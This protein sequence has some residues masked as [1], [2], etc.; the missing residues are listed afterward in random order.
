MYL[1]IIILGYLFYNE[2]QYDSSKIYYYKAISLN[3]KYTDAYYN[4]AVTF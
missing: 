2:N 3:P 1:H 4:I